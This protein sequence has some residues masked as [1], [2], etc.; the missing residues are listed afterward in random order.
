MVKHAVTLDDKYTQEHGQVFLSSVQAL[1]RIP[2]VQ[3]RRDL[4]AGLNTAGYITGYRGSPLGVY[5]AALWA[6]SAHLKE[7]GVEFIPGVNEELA[8]ASC[9]GTQQLHWFEKPRYDGVFAYW[10]AKGLGVDR[11]HEALKMGNFEG[12]ARHGGVLLICGDDHGGKSSATAHQ[13]E[14][15]LEAA[16]IPILYPANTQEFLEYGLYGI[17]MSRFSG[18]WV[19]FKVTNDTVEATATVNVD[20]EDIEVVLP[21]DHPQPPNSLNILKEEI[22]P[23]PQEQ[24]LVRYRLPAVQAFVR[25][26]RIDRVVFDS[27]RR[28]LGIVTAGKAYLDVR[29]A[30]ADLGISEARARM[31]GLRIYKLGLTWPVEPQGLLEFVRGHDEILVV[32]EKRAFIESQLKQILYNQADPALRPPVSGKL[33]LDGGPLIPADGETSPAMLCE[34]LARRLEARGLLQGDIADAVAQRRQELVQSAAAPTAPVVRTAYFCSGCPHNSSTVVPEGAVAYAGVGC[35]ALAH[36][37]PSRPTAWAVQMGG[38]GTLWLGM[39][40]FTGIPHV[41]QNLG[42]GTYFHSGSLAIRASVGAGSNITYKLL[43]NDAIAMTGGQPIDGKL[44][45]DMM[46]RQIAAEGAQ[47]VVIVTDQPDKYPAGTDW[48]KGLSIH[49]RS[50][51]VTV[52]EQ[53]SRV[54][55]VTALLYDQTCAAE[56][57]RRRK[58]GLMPDPDKRTFINAAVCEGCGDCSVKSNC[59]S[60]QPLETELGRKRVIDQ[61]NCN[62]DFS[63]VTGFCPSFVTVY[64]ARL[65]KA[66]KGKQAF[67]PETLFAGLPQPA[68]PPLSGNTGILVTG[69][70]GTGVLTVTA[71]LGMAAHLENRGCSIMDMTGMAQ[72]NGAVLSHLR[73]APGPD[74]IFATRIGAA[75]AAVVIGCDM[76][77]A[78]GMEAIRAVMPGKTRSVINTTIVPTA[79]FQSNKNIDFQQATLLNNIRKAHG[80]PEQVSTVDATRLAT[81]LLGDSIASNL[82]MVGYAVQKGLVPLSVEPILEAIRLNGVAVAM[83]Q[84]AFQ[85]GRLAAHD[86]AAVEKA[87]LAVKASQGSAQAG[88]PAPSKTLDELIERRRALLSAYQNAAYAG[89]YS[90]LVERARRQE[91]QVLGAG[92]E[93]LTAAVAR[94][95]ARVMAYKD[96]YEVARLYSS[97]EFQRQLAQTF[98]GDY[99]VKFNLA[100]PLFSKRDPRTGHLVKREYPAWMMSAFRFL[101]RFRG[102][103]GT[104]LDI[105]GRTAERRMERQLVADYE[106]L[107]QR[108]L[109][110][111][112]PDRAD[113]A[114][115]LL[116]LYE[117]IRGYGHVKERNFKAVREQEGQLL[118]RYE[119]RALEAP[120]AP[121]SLARKV[122]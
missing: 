85:W 110:R 29:Q 33:D 38:E 117:D 113:L 91:Q 16:M 80:S 65:R 11:G 4:K 120:A 14:Q 72:K 116:S 1:V 81:A 99:T 57:R 98:E 73:L 63:C 89:R 70:G 71:I 42:D 102:L 97:G 103:R 108:V 41:F 23:I 105:F 22:F 36:F 96:E 53:L 8:A 66:E 18:C 52:E 37:M 114:V 44:T 51:L 48:P 88:E 26:N 122:S 111:L 79:Q 83:N 94:T 82:F 6:A 62:K 69:I 56:K 35:H 40:R 12:A 7:S 43:Y 107:A 100:P 50:E 74:G 95:Y 67:E 106:A 34:V 24:K 78:A 47:K 10:Y 92:S 77:V 46:A 32:E 61:S 104:P 58:R 75:S 84:Q 39:H 15:V 60:V 93:R 45:I 87:V 90:A 54:P 3:K 64:G 28:T 121:A 76:V 59:V 31:L 86:L 115:Q 30:L 9:R 118:A 55:G 13:S 2:L 17:A 68:T 21:T 101:A 27:S 112:A 49:H 19:A 109:D 25:A 5:D 119:G 20:V